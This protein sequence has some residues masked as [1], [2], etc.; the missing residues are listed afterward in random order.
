MDDGERALPARRIVGRAV[1]GFIV[2][3]AI[4]ASV[5]AYR[6][7]FVNPRTDAA[8]VR[9]NVVGIAPQVSGPIVELH[10]VD[11]QSVKQ[12]D[13]LF[14]IDCRPYEARLARTRA[15]MNVLLFK[16]ANAFGLRSGTCRS[17]HVVG[18]NLDSWQSQH[19]RRGPSS[20]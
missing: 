14:T 8:A 18:Q 19:H 3:G 2:V 9:A 6:L 4:V 5:Y 17:S 16:V 20:C 10:V 11:N 15:D 13:L 1:G 12:G 7:N